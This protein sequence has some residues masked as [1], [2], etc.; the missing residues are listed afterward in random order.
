MQAWIAQLWKYLGATPTIWKGL[1]LTLHHLLHSRRKGALV[2]LHP[3]QGA[4]PLR[5]AVTIRYPQE[6]LKLPDHGRNRLHNEIDDCIVC[7][8]CARVCPVD[9][10]SIE[11]IRS[12]ELIGH[13]SDGTP[14][15]LH[16]ARFDIDMAKCCFCGLCTVVCP[17]ECLSMEPEYAYSTDKIQDHVLSFAK[18]SNEEATTYRKQWQSYLDTKRAQQ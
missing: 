16:A 7:D 5:G 18:L 14:K 8:K 11:S 3:H 4:L 13:T 10:I 2:G 9:C 12:A 6:Q 1:Q 17:T 15:R